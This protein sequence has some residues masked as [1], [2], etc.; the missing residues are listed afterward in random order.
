MPS[1]MTTWFGQIDRAQSIGETLSVARDFFASMTPK[2]IGQLP[3][4][5]RPGRLR[6]EQDIEALHA[7]LVETYRESRAT[8][9]ELDTLQRMT[10]FV[11]RLSIR[12]SELGPTPASSSG[13]GAGGSKDGPEMSLAPRRN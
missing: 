7:S 2:E 11:V 6:D 8:G 3:L 10:S 4:V 9:A 5:C 12:L 1:T 13:G